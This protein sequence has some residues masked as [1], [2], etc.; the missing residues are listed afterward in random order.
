MFS[1]NFYHICTS[2]PRPWIRNHGFLGTGEY[3]IMTSHSYLKF[4]TT[5][6]TQKPQCYHQWLWIFNESFQ[7]SWHICSHNGNI[8]DVLP[9]IFHSHRWRCHGVRWS[10]HQPH[11]WGSCAVV[12]HLGDWNCTVTL[13]HPGH[14]LKLHLC[15]PSP[16]VMCDCVVFVLFDHD[17]AFFLLYRCCGGEESSLQ[18][19][20]KIL[21]SAIFS[22]LTLNGC[23]LLFKN[24]KI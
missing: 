9:Y 23:P 7:N 15:L 16:L 10:P 24:I 6:Q 8:T 22:L 13:L 21:T 17:S 2:L 3:W 1:L 14:S 20:L 18:R 11:L 5:T 12:T 19:E 4:Y